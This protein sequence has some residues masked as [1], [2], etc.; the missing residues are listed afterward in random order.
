MQL[1]DLATLG[2]ALLSVLI[3]PRA[4][5]VLRTVSVATWIGTIAAGICCLTF[6]AKARSLIESWKL[7]HRD[8]RAVSVAIALI[9]LSFLAAE[10]CSIWLR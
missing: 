8:V 3:W 5:P 7:R 10:H 6:W 4:V 9:W 2:V 1:L